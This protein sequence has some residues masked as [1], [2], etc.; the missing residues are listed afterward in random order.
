M[1]NLTNYQSDYSIF[2]PAMSGFYTTYIGRQ[3]S[4]PNYVDAN[5]M[6]K[7]FPHGMESLN[8][9]NDKQAMFYYKWF[10]YSGGHANLNIHEEDPC[11]DMIRKRDRKTS[12][13]LADSGGFQIGKG[14]WA[15]EWNDPTGPVVAQRMADCIARKTENRPVLDK[16]GN[17]ALDKNGNP[18]VK[19]VDL[20]KEYQDKLD[21]VERQRRSVLEWI[22]E[23]A[24]YGMILDVPSWISK[25]AYAVKQTGITSF[26]EALSATEYNNEYFI[27]HRK[28][29]AKFLNVL[30]G[31][32]HGTA[33]KWYDVMKKYCDPKQYPGRHFNGWAMGGQNGSDITLILRRIITMMHDGLLEPGVHDWMHFLGTSKLE[34][35]LVLTDIQRAV[36]KY[37]NPNFTI[38]Y[39]CASPFLATAN[40]QIYTDIITEKDGNWTYRMLRGLD[41]KKY[42]TDQRTYADAVIQDGIFESGF[43]S[44]PITDAIKVSDVCVYKPGDLNK[45]GKEGRTSWDSFSYT[46][47]MAHNIW[48]H[49]VAVQSANAEYDNNVIPEMLIDMKV[50]R[51]TFRDMIEHVF[52]LQD[53]DKAIQ[54][55]NSEENMI[56]WQ[57][58]KSSV[59]NTGKNTHNAGP[60][61][62][63]K[64]E[65]QG[66]IKMEKLMKSVSKVINTGHLDVQTNYETKKTAKKPITTINSS[67][68]EVM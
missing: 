60:E 53:K 41:D 8:I 4:D 57:K 25:D 54:F 58:F 1:Q 64:F 29:K 18:K 32:D 63:K 44:S 40:G 45:I 56:F 39:D 19:V 28:G 7:A 20:V 2:L 10:L 16:N 50:E 24:D 5:R 52:A 66:N 11:E 35:A 46:L 34:V 3:R 22:D 61:Y 55:I 31:M 67:I 51:K 12:F 30:Q 36:R 6:P 15:G 47:Q 38:S 62:N 68:V 33:D 23:Y 9:I 27:K 48:M 65:A 59:G 17:P 13:M 49:I 37:H 26:D 43:M 21:T 14:V 42:A